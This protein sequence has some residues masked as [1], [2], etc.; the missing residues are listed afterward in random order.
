MEQER[1]ICQ[2][3]EKPKKEERILGMDVLKILSMFM[4]VVLHV[5]SAGGILWNSTTFETQWWI[6]HALEHICIVAVNLFAMASGF[7]CFGRKWQIKKLLALWLQVFFYCLTITIIFMAIE[8]TA[9]VTWG[10]FWKSV[11][12]RFGRTVLVF[13]F[14][15]LIVFRDSHFELG[16]RT[17]YE[18]TSTVLFRRGRFFVND[19]Y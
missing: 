15:F 4:V 12:S 9:T 8:G 7:L 3:L 13:Y 2:R 17:L 19:W 6:A 14:L 10:G 5:N 16:N 1:T 11:Y 18:K